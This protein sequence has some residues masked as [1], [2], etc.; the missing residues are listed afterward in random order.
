VV[1]GGS[2]TPRAPPPKTEWR[3]DSG[4]QPFEA[5]AGVSELGARDGLLSGRTTAEVSIL[6]VAPSDGQ[7]QLYAFEVRLRISSGANLSVETVGSEEPD[8]E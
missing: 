3:F 1:E 2:A 7:Y 8:R 6:D 5:L 4:S